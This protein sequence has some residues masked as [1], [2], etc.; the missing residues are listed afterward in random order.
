L[1]EVFGL[2]T[3]SV[4]PG[5][6]MI[7]TLTLI[8]ALASCSSRPEIQ[9]L[10][11]TCQAPAGPAPVSCEVAVLVAQAV[12]TS[13]HVSTE[14]PRVEV[15]PEAIAE[16]RAVSAWWVTFRSAVYH[17][18]QGRSCAPRSFTVIVDAATG[19]LLAWDVPPFGC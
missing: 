12:A 17:P 6:A 14:G 18:L 19:R 1:S 7:A 5:L 16:G 10:N 2:A 3:V 15:K 11:P 13:N 4:H 8:S 9:G